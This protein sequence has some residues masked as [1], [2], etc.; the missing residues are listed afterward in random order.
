M[1]P[2]PASLSFPTSVSASL[3]SPVLEEDEDLLAAFPVHSPK[4][5]QRA[6]FV[7]VPEAVEGD[8]PDDEVGDVQSSR[9]EAP[10]SASPPP[11]APPSDP[12]TAFPHPRPLSRFRLLRLFLFPSHLTLVRN[13][14]RRLFRPIVRSSIRLYHPLLLLFLPAAH[15]YTFCPLPL[16]HLD[17]PLYPRHRRV[18]RLVPLHDPHHRL[19]DE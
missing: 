1:N 19:G 9:P 11:P 13:F 8:V 14:L 5:L 7:A 3:L 16:N 18:R 12:G 6:L 15:S 17:P 10:P 4:A 2:S